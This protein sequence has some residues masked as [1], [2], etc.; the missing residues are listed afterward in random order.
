LRSIKI[1]FTFLLVPNNFYESDKFIKNKNLFDII[2]DSTKYLR[3]FLYSKCQCTDAHT[4][5]IK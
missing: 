2:N 3:F 4:S 5:P 1:D